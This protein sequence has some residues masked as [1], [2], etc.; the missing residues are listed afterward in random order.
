MVVA[1]IAT[2][3]SCLV[4]T[5]TRAQTE[6]WYQAILDARP[7]WAGQIALHQL[8]VG[9]LVDHALAGIVRQLFGVIRQHFGRHAGAQRGQILGRMPHNL[10]TLRRMMQENV[11]DFRRLRDARHRHRRAPG[12][13]ARGAAAG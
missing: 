2:A 9:Q 3:A 6:L 8:D 12:G 5:N 13:G 11:D 4:F 10:K 7:E 1:E